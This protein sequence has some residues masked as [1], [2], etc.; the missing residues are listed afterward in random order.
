MSPAA[1]GA[2]SA[3]TMTEANSVCLIVLFLLLM[4]LLDG[5]TVA[6]RRGAMVF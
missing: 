4:E 2:Q 5:M 3:S 1:A 6:D